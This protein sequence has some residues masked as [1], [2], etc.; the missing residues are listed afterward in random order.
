M[1][2]NEAILRALKSDFDDKDLEVVNKALDA[3]IKATPNDVSAFRNAFKITSELEGFWQSYSFAPKDDD[4]FLLG[5]GEGAHSSQNNITALR[6]LAGQQRVILNLDKVN[7]D[8]LNNIAKNDTDAPSMRR[9]IKDNKPTLWP[10]PWD[11]LT[12]DQL[13]DGNLKV[14]KEEAKKKLMATLISKI[15]LDDD[16]DNLNKGFLALDNYDSDDVPKDW[17]GESDKEQIKA[18]IKARALVLAQVE[19][20]GHDARVQLVDLLEADDLPSIKDKAGAIFTHKDWITEENIDT[21]KKAARK[22]LTNKIK[23]EIE[24]L[25]YDVGHDDYRIRLI[26]AADPKNIST[27]QRE[28][29]AVGIVKADSLLKEE[30]YTA[31]LDTI[32]NK[33]FEMQVHKSSPYSPYGKEIHKALIDA[34]KAATPEK[35]EIIFSNLE[36]NIQ[37]LM[38]ATNVND[39]KHMLGVED[40]VANLVTEEN[41]RLEKFKKIHSLEAEKILA[42]LYATYCPSEELSDDVINAFNAK[43]FEND[44]NNAYTENNY[45]NLIQNVLIQVGGHLPRAIDAQKFYNAF[46]LSNDGSVVRD[47]DEDRAIKKLVTDERNSNLPLAIDIHKNTTSPTRPNADPLRKELMQSFLRIDKSSSPLGLAHPLDGNNVDSLWTFFNN[48]KTY[49]EFK[50][51]ITNNTTI[52]D[53]L[54][55]DWPKQ[56]TAADFDKLKL[57]QLKQLNS[58][59]DISKFVDKRLEELKI[60]ENKKFM[61]EGQ[62]KI[63]EK[64]GGGSANINDVMRLF[65]PAFMGKSKAEAEKMRSRLMKLAESYDTI[66]RR[67]KQQKEVIEG[68]QKSLQAPDSNMGKKLKGKIAEIDMILNTY[69]KAQQQLVDHILPELQE[70]IESKKVIQVF[71][72]DSGVVPKVFKKGSKEYEDVKNKRFRSANLSEAS[73]THGHQKD[74]STDEMDSDEFRILDVTTMDKGGSSVV[75]RIIEEHGSTKPEKVYASD[76]KIITPRKFSV[77][78]PKT[79]NPQERELIEKARMKTAMIAVCQLL[80]ELDGP[81]DK[82]HPIR[83][84][85]SDPEDLKYLWTAVKIAQ[86]ELEGT[87]MAFKD[88]AIQGD[89]I[90]YLSKTQKGRLGWKEDSVY[91]TV[92][93]EKENKLVWKKIVDK[94]KGDVNEKFKHDRAKGFIYSTVNQHWFKKEVQERVKGAEEELKKEH[95]E[96]TLKH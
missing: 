84:N 23:T 48:S 66:I 4:N 20:A 14:I 2:K 77:D 37:R 35:K 64:I 6:Q 68:L 94:L 13:T 7:N 70:V 22:G 67:M 81:P 74:I 19:L 76:K 72:P 49:E 1:A 36:K 88:D 55:E 89:S 32:R 95:K 69:E 45:P 8:V 58:E 41:G 61:S 15:N 86:K 31:L 5:P 65:N 18:A 40:N 79:N 83:I 90:E 91:K 47:S 53:K 43:F 12:N 34:F 52:K 59:R 11:D 24:A 3:L 39:V 46:G 92:F 78:V 93:E 44:G 56:F 54:S 21:L 42:N 29:A 27:Y 51:N 10:D 75:S 50:K 60:R 28:L 30:N 82:K 63:L 80:D 16:L 71:G 96:S 26:K 57:K 62:R 9:I 25:S 85:G 38:H 17:I 33:A 73:V 87:K